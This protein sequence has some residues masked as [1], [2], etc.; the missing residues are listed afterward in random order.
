MGVYIGAF[1][2]SVSFFAWFSIWFNE[3][4][5]VRRSSLSEGGAKLPPGSMGLPLLGEMLDFLWCFKYSRSPDDFIAKRK[6]R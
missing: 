3:W 4:R 1:V 6:I 2:V 5:F